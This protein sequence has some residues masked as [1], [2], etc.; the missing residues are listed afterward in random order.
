MIKDRQER[1][2]PAIREL[3][4]EAVWVEETGEGNIITINLDKPLLP[5]S[6]DQKG[7]HS[8]ERPGW[9]EFFLS[10]LKRFIIVYYGVT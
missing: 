9:Y 8:N 5:V 2:L 10:Q 6:V 1:F 4:K 3:K 7:H